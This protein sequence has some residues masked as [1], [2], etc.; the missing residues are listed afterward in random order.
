MTKPP[1]PSPPFPPGFIVI[2]SAAGALLLGFLIGR[3]NPTSAPNSANSASAAALQ[4]ASAFT[5]RT[6]A[7]DASTSAR[8]STRETSER[9]REEASA[10]SSDPVA[11]LRAEN[12][13]GTEMSRNVRMI[14]IL[15]QLSEDEIPNVLIYATGL[16]GEQQRQERAIV[17]YGALTRWAQFN[18]D[19]SK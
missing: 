14:G 18:D 19:I 1:P 9:A 10:H 13:T 8:S 5:P 2:A 16:T 17:F 4:A 7:D 11:Q 6:S 3:I 15:S 12:Q